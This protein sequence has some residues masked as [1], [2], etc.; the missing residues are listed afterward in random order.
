[1]APPT[2]APHPCLTEIDLQPVLGL[3]SIV[4]LPAAEIPALIV[5]TH[6]D[7]DPAQ[8]CMQMFY[9]LLAL[10]QNQ[11]ALE[12]QARALQQRPLYR[13][14]GPVAP[15][16]RLLALMGPGNMMDNTPFEFLIENSDIRLDLLF[17]EAGQALP[18]T[19]PDHDVTIVAVGESDKNTPLL[20][21]LSTLLAYWPRPV[22]N[23][24][25]HILHCARNTSYQL[26][27]DIPGLLIPLTQRLPREQV[28]QTKFPITIRPMDTHGGI[29]MAKL[30]SVV[31]LDAYC[32]L[33]PASEY[34]VADYVDYRSPDGLFRKLRIALIDGQP[35]I[36]HLAISDH[37]MVHYHSAN[38]ELSEQKRDEEAE[39][40]DNFDQGF[41]IQHGPA[42]KA[43][44]ERLG[45]DY[46]ILDCAQTHDGR[47]LLFEVDSRAWIHA[48]DSL[49]LFP[50][51]PHVMQKAFDAFRTLL[52]DRIGGIHA[53]N[54]GNVTSTRVIE[55]DRRQC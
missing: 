29:G 13:I 39:L 15:V 11:F 27:S 37:W 22:L 47:L 9:V 38:M 20:A 55:S 36:C 42:L 54:T 46:V 23:D 53:N 18:D 25:L 12:M 31:E 7:P 35:Y 50:R 34:F 14:A 48:T 43:I 41:A 30:D 16:I 28:G 19:L 26:L 3:L 17:L 33:H 6:A 2:A 45:L 5:K 49:V 32:A 10:D 52:L 4:R 51:K 40:M 24:P 8:L 44:A 1:M 21:H